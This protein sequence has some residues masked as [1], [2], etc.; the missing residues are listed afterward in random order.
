M[1]DEEHEHDDVEE[2]EHGTLHFERSEVAQPTL[3]MIAALHPALADDLILAQR[4]DK[5]NEKEKAELAAKQEAVESFV[6]WTPG[7]WAVGDRC[8]VCDSPTTPIFEDHFKEGKLAFGAFIDDVPVHLRNE[9]IAGFATKVPRR[10]PQVID[11]LRRQFTT[12]RARPSARLTQFFRHD[13][14]SQAPFSLEDWANSVAEAN[15]ETLGR[16]D[17]RDIE[18]LMNWVHKR[19]FH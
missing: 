10:A 17:A 2:H 1:T 11:K 6:T 13:L 19:L 3:T 15:A 5:L 16:S 18:R 4:F 14:I 8:A 9:C 7:F 12:D